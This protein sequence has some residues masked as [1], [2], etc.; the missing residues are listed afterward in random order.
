M[1]VIRSSVYYRIL[2]RTICG[3]STYWRFRSSSIS[4]RVNTRDPG[5][6]IADGTRR[7]FVTITRSCDEN[8][9]RKH[10]FLGDRFEDGTIDFLSVIAVGHGLDALRALAG[11]MPAIGQ[12]TF[13][14]AARLYHRMHGT[15]H[16]NGRPMFRMYADTGYERE[17][18]Q[19]GVVNFNVL[20]ANGDHLG[21]NEVSAT[22][23]AS[24]LSKGTVGEGRAFDSFRDNFCVRTVF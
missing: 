17:D 15:R 24:V 23:G 22:P 13:G 14:L 1:N 19:G 10:D 12:R 8:A 18:T 20:R 4:T 7:C 5:K 9:P 3:I 16:G 6:R 2:S 11:P 21:H